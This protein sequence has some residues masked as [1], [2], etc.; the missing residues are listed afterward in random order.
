MMFMKSAVSL[1]RRLQAAKEWS[2][3]T[4]SRRIYRFVESGV[5]RNTIG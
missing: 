2:L 4:L 3:L 1:R 5:V